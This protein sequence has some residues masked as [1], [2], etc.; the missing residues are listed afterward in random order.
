MARPSIAQIIA[1]DRGDHDVTKP[2]LAHGLGQAPGLVGIRRHGPP[3][4]D[5]AEGAASRAEVA[6]DHEGG[7]AV[8]EAL[9]DVRARGFLAHRHQ[10]VLAQLCLERRHRSGG[11]DPDANPIGLAQ[12]SLSGRIETN[13]IA[14]HLVRAGLPLA[15]DEEGNVARIGGLDTHRGNRGRRLLELEPEEVGEFRS[16]IR[17]TSATSP[18]PPQSSTC[19]TLRPRNPQGL[20]REN[21]SRSMFTLSA[22][23]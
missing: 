13:G 3:M 1:I 9:V 4:R 23:P 5:V 8:A 20:M 15:F 16:R 19:V 6:E 12:P 17:A 18:G 22:M 14:G 2:H 11:R 10:P 21:G 7:G